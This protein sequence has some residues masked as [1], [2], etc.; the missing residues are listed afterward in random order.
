MHL[1]GLDFEPRLPRLSDR[2]LYAFEPRARYGRLAPLFGNGSTRR[3][4]RRTGTR[5]AA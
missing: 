5:S 1:L 3:S 2:R 4:S